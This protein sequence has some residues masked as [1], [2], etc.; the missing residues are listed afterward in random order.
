MMGQLPV[1]L[2]IWRCMRMR[3]EA[4]WDACESNGVCAGL[5][6][7]VFE[8][9]DQDNLNILLDEIPSRLEQQVRHA[10]SSCPKLALRIT[11]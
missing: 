7:E 10:V 3:V 8:V 5:V 6:P 4:D 1:M 2:A 11:E 9:D